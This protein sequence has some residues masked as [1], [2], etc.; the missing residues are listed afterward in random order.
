MLRRSRNRHPVA[1]GRKVATRGWFTPTIFALGM[2]SLFS[3]AGHETATAILPLFIG[4]LGGS[5]AALGLIE[6]VADMLSTGAKLASGWYSDGL[7]H[8]KPLGIVG[9][10]ATGVGMA[11]FALAMRPLHVLLIRSVSWIGRG[12]RGPA[13]DAMLTEAVPASAVGRAFGFDRAMDSVGAVIGPLIA[14]VLVGRLGFRAIF[15]VTLVPGILSVAAFASAQE[16][17]VVRTRASFRASLRELPPAFRRFLLAVGMFGLG[18]FARSLLILRAIEMLGPDA[19]LGPARTAIALYVF[20]NAVH[21]ASAYGIGVLGS[22]FGARRVLVGG[23]AAFAIMSAGFI[24]ASSHAGFGLLIALFLLAGLA[25]SAE[26]V[27]ERTAAAELLPAGV[28]GT[29]FGALAAVNGIGDLVASTVVGWL[30]ATASPT[31]GF[32][33]AAGMAAAG[34]L[35]LAWIGDR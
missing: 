34:T 7:H 32:A 31:A 18:D 1:L 30:W 21:A 26:E 4:T 8:R 3:D 9:Y 35:A 11:T 17:G 15:A 27:L 5:A 23:Y 33:Y 19:P 20:H 2:A 25:L 28:R 24:V 14:L 10:A 16:R 12:M 22:R 29:G 6:G 13:R